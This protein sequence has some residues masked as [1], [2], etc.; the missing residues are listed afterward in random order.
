M[1]SGTIYEDVYICWLG[2]TKTQI[3]VHIHI[4]HTTQNSCVDPM[5]SVVKKLLSN[6]GGEFE[7]SESTKL[8]F[9]LDHALHSQFMKVFDKKY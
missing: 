2:S 3:K 6:A 8:G 9:P 4:I 5:K 7:E 1:K